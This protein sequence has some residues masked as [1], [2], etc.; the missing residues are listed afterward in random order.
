MK[1]TWNKCLLLVTFLVVFLISCA[2]PK[3]GAPGATGPQ[4]PPGLPG[5]S[6]SFK[7]FCPS[8][9]GYY[10]GSYGA[11]GL[12]EYYIQVGSNI[13]AILDAGTAMSVY[14]TLVAPGTY[15]TSDGSG[16]RFTVQA[17]GSIIEL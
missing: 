7:R 5:T 13:Y 14:L 12:Q 15:T 10:A 17:D 8:R 3:D 4:G 11:L 1:I 16:C 2:P 9:A 6:L